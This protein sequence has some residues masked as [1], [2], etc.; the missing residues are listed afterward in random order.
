MNLNATLRLI[1]CSVPLAA[2]AQNFY[3]IALIGDMPYGADN[4]PK[5][6]RV[7]ADINRHNPAFTVHVGDTKSGSTRCDDAHYTKTL[8][9]FNS[10][11]S[12]LVY[13]PGDN[14]W[15]DCM[16]T[17]NGAFDPLD[18]L[19][20]IRR[21]YFNGNLSLGK[22]PIELMRQSD[23]PGF[24]LY[25][26]NAIWA[27]G[28]V[29]FVA[30]HIVGSN[31]NLEYRD[32]QGAPNPFYDNDREY[33]ARNAANQ[34]WLRKAFQMAREWGSYGIMILAQANVF[35]SYLSTTEGATRSGFADFIGLLREETAKF[36]GQVVMVSGD[37]HYTRVDKPLTATY[38]PCPSTNAACRPDNA[39]GARFY[40]FTRVE[41][42]GQNDNH[43]V[44]AR[45][46]PLPRRPF[47]FELV[48]VPEN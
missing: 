41:V 3:D 20:L 11:E 26:E 19:S 30:V 33:T 45:V 42:P 29:V 17:S 44:R 31:N 9:W 14:E 13:T 40:N 2:A 47:Q 39:P 8:N 28:P 27:R 22:R 12:A 24:A 15:T 5:Y 4:E 34:A 6:E 1:L 36:D 43:W 21:M 10:F 25:R 46:V 38:P 37:S 48:V 18:R 32:V 16:R 35:E 7:I 23:E